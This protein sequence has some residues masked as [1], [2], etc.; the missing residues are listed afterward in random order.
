MHP[1]KNFHFFIFLS[2]NETVFVK[3]KKDRLYIL[4]LGNPREVPLILI[5]WNEYDF[6][7]ILSYLEWVFAFVFTIF[8]L[9]WSSTFSPK[10][11]S[12]V[13]KFS[14]SSIQLQIFVWLY[15]FCRREK[16]SVTSESCFFYI[17][18]NFVQI[19]SK[20][21]QLYIYWIHFYMKTPEQKFLRLASA[22]VQPQH[23]YIA[24]ANELMSFIW[25]T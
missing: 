2:P 7:S 10:F 5:S 14:F 22:Y 20:K 6:L 17:K 24:F 4:L 9:S 23:I 3:I 8:I 21:R 18:V 15:C 25:L 13:H 16:L 19:S 1:I 11:K 12:L